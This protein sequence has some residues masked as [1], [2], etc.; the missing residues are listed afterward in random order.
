MSGLNLRDKPNTSTAEVKDGDECGGRLLWSNLVAPSNS[1][2]L[3]IDK[4]IR[5]SLAP[6]NM[7]DKFKEGDGLHDLA[8]L[9]KNSR[10]VTGKGQVLTSE[11]W[12]LLFK[13]LYQESSDLAKSPKGGKL[14]IFGLRLAMTSPNIIFEGADWVKQEGETLGLQSGLLT[15]A[16]TGAYIYFGAHWKQ[17]NSFRDYLAPPGKT[18]AKPS[19]KPHSFFDASQ[20][21][22]LTQ[23]KAAHN[24]YQD[25][26]ELSD[27]D[28]MEEPTA[29]T[30]DEESPPTAK[31]PSTPATP[32]KTF[33]FA[34]QLYIRKERNQ[35][36][37]QLQQKKKKWKESRK[38]S[39]FLKI[40]TAKLKSDDRLGQE[41]EFLTV[42]QET[43]TK[44]WTLDPKLVI[45]PYKKGMEGSKPIQ[46]GKPF[47]GNRDAFAD[48]TEKV[49]LKRGEK[50]W[51]RLHVGHNKQITALR[52]DRMLDHFRQKDMLVYKGNLQAKTT[53]KAGCLLGSYPTVLNC[54]MLKSR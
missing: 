43:L 47:P 44:L 52:D 46:N 1:T 26:I 28:A 8:Y 9:G 16:W 18:K 4:Q 54:T 38:F 27:N 17:E 7:F 2:W 24:L 15:D 20:V 10:R 25:P 34:R 14:R 41:E 13:E 51:I 37:P 21:M 29:K 48:F 49:F 45:F 11:G 53:A 31:S 6:Y 3:N 36:D 23:E 42:M 32:G 30:A 5:D 12:R 40:C 33:A 22:K 19:L 39:S 50:V 35:I